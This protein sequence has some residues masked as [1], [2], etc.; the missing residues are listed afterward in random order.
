VKATV[1]ALLTTAD[2]D[3]PVKFK[4]SDI[5]REMQF[6]KLGKAYGFESIPNECLRHL[7]RRPLIDLTHLLNHC[8]QLCH[9]LALW[10]S[11]ESA[12]IVD[13]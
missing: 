12:L 7:P 4:P 3:N 1:Q 8:L 2:E 5:S 9:F 13:D 6:F 10:L 11:H